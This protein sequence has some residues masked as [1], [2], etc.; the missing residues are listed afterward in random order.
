MRIPTK[1]EFFTAIYALVWLLISFVGS[2][3][4]AISDAPWAVRLILLGVFGVLPYAL[5]IMVFYCV[6]TIKKYADHHKLWRK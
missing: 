6:N 3:F 5:I 2:F 4:F 1:L